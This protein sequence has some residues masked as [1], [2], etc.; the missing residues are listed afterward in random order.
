MA[1]PEPECPRRRRLF[2]NGRGAAGRVRP[3]PAGGRQ[4]AATRAGTVRRRRRLDLRT[5]Q[6]RQYYALGAS[7]VL[8]SVTIQPRYAGLR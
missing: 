7:G 6:F 2:E 8:V 1:I 5:D 4:Q 3:M